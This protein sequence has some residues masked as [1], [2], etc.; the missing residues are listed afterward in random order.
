ME[1]WKPIEGY[2]NYQVSNLGRVKSMNYNKTKK[3]AVLTPILTGKY[4]SVSLWSDTGKTLVSVH[5][6]V[7]LTFLDNPEKKPAVDHING[8]K[9]DNRL[10][11]LK[12]SSYSEN[13]LNKQLYRGNNTGELNISFVKSSGLFQVQIQRNKKRF[14]KYCTSLAEAIQE[15]DNY[16]NPSTVLEIENQTIV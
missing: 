3:E 2:P 13:N 12:W 7:A 4:Y 14:H 5:R 15:R 8:N 11:N 9:L 16:L 10:E 6:L 1:E